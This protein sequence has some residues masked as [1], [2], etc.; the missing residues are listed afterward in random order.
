MRVRPAQSPIIVFILASSFLLTGCGKFTS[1]ETSDTVSSKMEPSYCST[2]SAVSIGTTVTATARYQ[3]WTMNTS[4]G[5]TMAYDTNPIR[6]AEVQILAA[7]GST[8]QC[9]ETDNN[10]NLSL[11]IPR[12]A[13]TYVLKFLSRA[14]NSFY[15]ASV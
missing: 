8:I 1:E 10:G 15:K 7:N 14:D 5:L 12:A 2:I 3:A 13:R 11:S 9:G 4:T 6:R